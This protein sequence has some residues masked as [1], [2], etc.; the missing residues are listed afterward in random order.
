ATDHYAAPDRRVRADGRA[1]ADERGLEPVLPRMPGA[2]VRDVREDGRRT[3]EHLGLELDAVVEAHVVLDAAAA[4]DLD[5]PR[6]E[7]V[8]AGHAAVP[9]RGARH[10]VAEVPDARALADLARLVDDRGRMD[11]GPRRAHGG[12]PS[13]RTH[14]TGTPPCPRLARAVSRMRSTSRP[15]RPP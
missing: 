10:H 3:D 2:R 15:C 13:G 8:R 4:S 14:T 12:G 1:L 5:A 11:A 9:D 7:D 6:D